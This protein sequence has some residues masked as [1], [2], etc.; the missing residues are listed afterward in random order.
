[1]P[2]CPPWA[3][4]HF[5]RSCVRVRARSPLV[6]RSTRERAKYPASAAERR[7]HFARSRGAGENRAA[8]GVD[9][10]RLEAR[11]GLPGSPRASRRSPAVLAAR[12]RTSGR[13][14]RVRRQGTLGISPARLDTGVRSRDQGG[15]VGERAEYRGAS[16]GWPWHFA[17]SAGGGRTKPRP[18]RNRSRRA[19]EM[20]GCV[21]RVTAA[22]R[23]LVVR[24]RDRRGRRG[25]GRPPGGAGRPVGAATGP[26]AVAC[27]A[28]GSRP[29]RAGGTP[30]C[31]RR[32]T[33]AF[34]P[35]AHPTHGTGG[36]GQARAG[37]RERAQR[38]VR[39]AHGAGIGSGTW[40][41]RMTASSGS[42]AR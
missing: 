42:T 19:G 27:T 16:T 39:E 21:H 2:E 32:A 34:R 10:D 24:R 37:Q 9:G 4:R 23:P 14:I 33:A 36:N 31:V 22:F 26:Q 40:Q 35:L 8:G 1:M 17:R 18:Q 25:G 41:P 29:G 13:N 5:A 12:V 6:P 30:G 20:P 7:R 15:G 38:H 3:P 28:C 11:G